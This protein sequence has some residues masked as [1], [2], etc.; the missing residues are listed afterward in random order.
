MR[1]EGSYRFEP[2]E[3]RGLLLGLG[4]GQLIVLAAAVLAAIG[5]AKTWPGAVGFL[6]AAGA[7]ASGGLLCRP[8]AGRPPSQWLRVAAS[9]ASRRRVLAQSP[10]AS[11]SRARFAPTGPDFCD[12]RVPLRAAG[13][14]RADGYRY[15]P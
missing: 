6:A 4:L 9:F 3:R 10:P 11:C 8:V 13:D 2:L 7:L 5:L 14:K 15:P 12:R 1:D